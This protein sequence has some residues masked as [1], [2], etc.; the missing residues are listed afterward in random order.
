L[1]AVFTADDAFD[2]FL[3]DDETPSEHGQLLRVTLPGAKLF[4]QLSTMSIDGVVFN[5]SGP[6]K[7]V[8]FAKAFLEVVLDAKADD[9][10]TR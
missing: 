2:A 3:P 8:A 9:R 4:E 6:T 7:P 5:C 10:V 1:A